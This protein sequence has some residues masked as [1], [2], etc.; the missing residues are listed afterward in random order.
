MRRSA[1]KIIAPLDKFNY[2]RAHFAPPQSAKIK[3]GWSLENPWKAK[4][5]CSVRGRFKNIAVLK[6]APR[7]RNSN[8][9]LKVPPLNLLPCG[10]EASILEYSIDGSPFKK[11]D[12]Y[13]KWSSQLYLPWVFMFSDE[14]REGKHK[15]CL[16]MS[17]KKS[18]KPRNRMP[19]YKFLR[20][21]KFT[22]IRQRQIKQA[23][24]PTDRANPILKESPTAMAATDI[25]FNPTRANEFCQ[26]HL[27]MRRKYR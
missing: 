24:A 10:D 17:A 5:K 18:R 21:L 20:K 4:I 1:Q 15:I 6:R 8:L 16:R 13:T 23:S 12:T 27:N 26:A 2:S 9:I 25:F 3:R 7:A 14:L 11:L 19:N 22:S